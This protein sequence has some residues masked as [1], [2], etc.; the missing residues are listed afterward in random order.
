M[1]NR[2]LVLYVEEYNTARS[3]GEIALPKPLC[4]C[5]APML[6]AHVRLVCSQA[7]TIVYLLRVAGSAGGG[8]T[9]ESGQGYM[10]TVLWACL[11][12]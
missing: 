5:H 3:Y 12:V 7:L 6:A 2:I 10:Q 9:A 1:L 4:A 11:S 8:G